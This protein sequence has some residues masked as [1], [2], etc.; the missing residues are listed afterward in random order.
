VLD[1]LGCPTPVSIIFT[2]LNLRT[3]ERLS[4]IPPNAKTLIVVEERYRNSVLGILL[5]HILKEN[6]E[7]LHKIDR[8]SLEKNLARCEFVVHSLAMGDLV[9]ECVTEK[10]TTILMDYEARPDALAKLRESFVVHE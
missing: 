2:E 5:Q 4:A 7:V 8:K 1:Q 10:H 6:V 3:V 9:A